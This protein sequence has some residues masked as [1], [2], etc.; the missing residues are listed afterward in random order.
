MSRVSIEDAGGEDP[1]ASTQEALSEAEQTTAEMS[2]SSPSPSPSPSPEPPVSSVAEESED[3]SATE[4]E[5]E[6]EDDEPVAAL[7]PEE[8]EN[9]TTT[10]SVMNSGLSED[11][12]AAMKQ[13]AESSGIQ[14]TLLGALVEARLVEWPGPGE[15]FVTTLIVIGMVA[16]SALVLLGLN[17]ILARASE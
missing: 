6:E 2:S 4:E 13:Y 14:R 12:M 9:K 7:A 17:T 11:D 16:G 5:E 3:P 15:A 1:A 8:K 10:F